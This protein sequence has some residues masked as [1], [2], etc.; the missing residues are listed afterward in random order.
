MLVRLEER[1]TRSEPKAS[2]EEGFL[3]RITENPRLFYSLQ[4]IPRI[5]RHL[6]SYPLIPLRGNFSAAAADDDYDG[7]DDDDGEGSA[8]V[9]ASSLSGARCECWLVVYVCCMLLAGA[10]TISGVR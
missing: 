4:L 9:I 5:I 8:W 2:A 3:K 6:P 1:Q 10:A 7:D